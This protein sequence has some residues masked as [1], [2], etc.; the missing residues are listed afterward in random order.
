MEQ[1]YTPQPQPVETQVRKKRL[2]IGFPSSVDT[3]ELRFPIT[4]EGV[5]HLSD[6]GM[7][8]L[9]ESGAG[10]S[11]HYSDVRYAEAGAIVGK[12]ADTLMADIVV[13]MGQLS[14][15]DVSMLRKG[16][17]LLSMLGQQRLTPE[18]V[19]C[20][21]KRHVAFVAL[22]RIVTSVGQHPFADILLEIDGRAAMAVA[23]AILLQPDFG[24]GILLGGVPGVIPCEVVVIGSNVGARAAAMAAVGMGAQVKML[25]NDVY[26]L[27]CASQV[28]GS[29]VATSVLNPHVVDN[30]LCSA[31]VVIA[32]PTA[33]PC[34][35]TAEQL[36]RAKKGVVFIDLN[37]LSA[38]VFPSVRQMPITYKQPKQEPGQRFCF[39]CVGNAAPRTAAMALSNTIINSFSCLGKLDGALSLI[40]VDAGI[41]A[42]VCTF[43]GKAVNAEFARA[44]GVRPIEMGLLLSCS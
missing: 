7:Q 31:D 30:A 32:T 43:M 1:D 38:S 28:L 4:P 26:G 25:D 3:G 18:F 14:A 21:L 29:A 13:S 11:I 20:L 36:A 42:A 15:S 5:G 8:A 39:R 37:P 10:S 17:V 22:E 24:K 16:T 35:F 27:R 9:V 19:N 41:Q 40:R 34:E 33:N 12:R 23:S 2:S 6:I 44:A